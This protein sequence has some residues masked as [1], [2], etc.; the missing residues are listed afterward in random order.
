MKAQEAMLI[1]CFTASLFPLGHISAAFRHLVVSWQEY[2]CGYCYR[3][4]TKL[5]RKTRQTRMISKAIRVN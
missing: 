3:K 4:K 2:H 5:V 1:S